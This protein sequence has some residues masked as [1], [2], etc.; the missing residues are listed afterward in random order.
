MPATAA[1]FV[2]LEVVLGDGV[3]GELGDSVV[4]GLV[5]GSEGQLQVHVEDVL[6]E[7]GQVQRL[8]PTLACRVK[9]PCVVVDTPHLF[10]ADSEGVFDE[11]LHLLADFDLLH[12]RLVLQVLH[13]LVQ[14]DFSVGLN[15]LRWSLHPNHLEEGLSFLEYVPRPA[16]VLVLLCELKGQQSGL[17]N[18]VRLEIAGGELIAFERA[19]L[20]ELGDLRVN[21]SEES[22][23]A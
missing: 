11:R 19:M 6:L 1:E 21:N 14:W 10:V 12:L 4:V 7:S 8:D 3:L 22:V 2:V 5:E 9:L 18:L 13:Q 16:E 23:V 15:Q 20:L 17:L